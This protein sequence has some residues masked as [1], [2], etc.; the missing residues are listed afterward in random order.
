MSWQT[1]RG[2]AEKKNSNNNMDENRKGIIANLAVG[3]DMVILAQAKR[4]GSVRRI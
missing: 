4:E 2:I 3:R 1:T